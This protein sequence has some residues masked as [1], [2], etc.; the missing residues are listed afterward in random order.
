[1]DWY[2]LARRLFVAAAA[3]TSLPHL[4]QASLPVPYAIVGC[5]SEGRFQSQGLMGRALASSV[6]RALEGK[7]IRIEGLLY[8][9]DMF[10]GSAIFIVDNECRN[11]LHKRYFLCDPCQTLPG[12]GPPSRMLPRQGGTIVSLPPAAMKE[13]DDYPRLMRR[14]P[15]P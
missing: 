9:G 7:T 11:N 2:R 5:I 14:E 8:P 6:L 10:R 15:P 12:V 13:L 1:M 4:A 3:V